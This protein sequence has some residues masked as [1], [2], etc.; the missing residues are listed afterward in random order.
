MSEWIHIES[1]GEH[2][3]REKSKAKA[4]RKT[5]WWKK[6]IAEGLCYYCKTKFHPQDLTM[7]HKIPLS[8]GGKST[9]GN[10]VV[11]CRNCNQMKKYYTPVD[12]ILEKLKKKES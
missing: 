6:K 10:I 9:K 2:I 11:A 4:L 3:L 12:L 5:N 8:R 7:D 1:D